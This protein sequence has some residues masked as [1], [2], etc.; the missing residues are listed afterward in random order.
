M[1]RAAI[2]LVLVVF[3][4]CGRQTTAPNLV[5]VTLD[6]TRTD[7]LSTYG[8]A[9]VSTAGLDRLASE[10]VVFD[11]ALSVAPLTLPAHSSLFTGLLPP[12]HGVRDNA[13]RPLA[14]EHQTLAEILRSRNFRTAA[15]VASAVLGRGRGLSQGFDVYDD[16][17]STDQ[18]NK[19]R[20]QRSGDEVVGGALEW[21]REQGT[22]R[23]FL[24]V[25]LYDAHAPYAPPAPFD[26]L[27]ATDPYAGEIA[28]ADA[29]LEWLTHELSRDG[30][31]KNTV[32]I[33]AGDHG[34]SLGEHGEREHGMFLYESVT[35]VPLV[36]T[37]PGLRPR[38]VS[39]VTRLVDV[40]PTALDLLGIDVPAVDGVS[41]Q[42]SMR[43]SVPSPGLD[44]YSESMYPA[45]FGWSPIRSLRDERFKLI[46]APR[47]ELYDLQRD[48]LE[49]HNVYFARPS[50]A[51]AMSRRLASLD[52]TSSL[53]RDRPFQPPAD[54]RERLRSLGYV[55]ETP[56]RD[57]PS[58]DGLA[59]VKDHIQQFNER[60]P[61]SSLPSGGRSHARPAP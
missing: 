32:V 59:D 51:A 47:P 52:P 13:D 12:R 25:H 55:G 31:L 60:F 40:M 23:F 33:V 21:L 48:P 10:G 43:G 44:G 1:R 7:Y 18:R 45:R 6:T 8:S 30:H 26:A 15:F 57:A 4:G 56:W 37:A 38:R 3:A 53:P 41:L 49:Q 61:S 28:F 39:S 20:A 58:A 9:R 29:Q 11:Q 24:W 54:V 46:A 36:I 16:G 27:Y 22:A 2:V 14:E 17:S 50:V 42:S 34:E 35:R 5:I 19:P